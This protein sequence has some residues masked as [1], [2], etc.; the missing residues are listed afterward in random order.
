MINLNSINLSINLGGVDLSGIKL[1]MPSGNTP[2]LPHFYGVEIPRGKL[3]PVYS[4]WIGEESYK[5][6]Q[7]IYDSFKA[8]KVKDGKVIGILNQSNWF[9]MEDGTPSGIVI[10]GVDVIDD[11]SDIM[12]VN[13]KPFYILNGGTNPDYERRI[14]SDEPFTYDGDKAIRVEPFG[15]VVDY[16]IVKNGVQRCIR[17]NTVPG[18]KNN[19]VLGNEYM[20]GGGWPTTSVSRFNYEKYAREKNTDKTSNIPYAN[21]FWFDLDIWSTLLFIKLGTKDLHAPSV[22]GKNISSNDSVNA[23]NWGEV[24]GIRV[25]KN[26]G[27]YLYYQF[28][29]TA[30]RNSAGSGYNFF[31]ILNNYRPVLKMIEPQLALSY[32]KMN[33]IGSGVQFEYDGNTYSYKNVPGCKGINEGD[34]T[35]IVYKYVTLPVTGFF[36]P[37]S[38]DVVDKPV[39]YIIAQSVVKGK[40]TDWGNCWV[41]VS[42]IDC[43]VDN[44]GGDTPANMYSIYHTYNAADLMTDTDVAEKTVDQKFTFE[45]QYEFVGNR[46]KQEGYWVNNFIGSVLGE[47]KGASLHTGEC[48]YGW[49][50]GP[51][52]TGK[53]ARRGVFF[54]AAAPNGY[55][56]LRSAIANDAPTLAGTNFAGGF[57]VAL[58][59]SES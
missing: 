12:L 26:D 56:S 31:S 13:I 2:R 39:E 43:V 4:S 35:G 5:D 46:Q 10:D 8:A 48:H 38:E 14:V 50:N 54:G 37:D 53:R 15:M 36:V 32:A 7:Y 20:T 47:I 40:R 28:S 19:G 57:R 33:N 59:P 34:M 44:T 9:E 41:W 29:S 18:T 16:S 51:A 3:D 52:S 25:Q 22:L 6:N 21:V 45:D 58:S 42:G 24:T 17:D 1:V 11:G 55:C 23:S 49:Y 30:F 27:T